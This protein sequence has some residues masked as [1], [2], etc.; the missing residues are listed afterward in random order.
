MGMPPRLSQESL[1]G[2]EDI[3]L[4]SLK[5]L[6]DDRLRRSRRGKLRRVILGNGAPW[7]PPLA[8]P[9]SRSVARTTMTDV[10]MPA[11]SRRARRLYCCCVNTGASSLTSSTYTITC[12]SQT[13]TEGQRGCA[14]GYHVLPPCT[15]PGTWQVLK[16]HLLRK[17]LYLT[18]VSATNLMGTCDELVNFS[19]PRVSQL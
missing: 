2:L 13:G 6:K 14:V 19:S 18:L 5:S 16:Y 17:E 12:R 3:K 8:S 1:L 11:V 15:A 9:V 7:L 10:P 4:G